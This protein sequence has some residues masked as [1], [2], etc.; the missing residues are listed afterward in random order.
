MLVCQQLKADRPIWIIEIGTGSGN[1]AVS[2]AKF[3]KNANICTIDVSEE[4]LELARA[5]ATRHAVE[6][7]ISFERM[8][9]FEP[10]DQLLLKRF[11]VL[12]SNPPYVSMKDWETLQLE[13]RKYEP[14]GAVC[15]GRDGFT[16][17]RRIIE[18]APYLLRD[19]GGL[20]LELGDHQ[21]ESV[22]GMMREAG[23]ASLSVVPDLQGLPRV[24]SSSCRS[25]TRNQRF[26]N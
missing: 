6:S 17:Y 11:D 3:I 15:D 25:K 12:V 9:V 2:L 8:D 1:I 21:S 5:N 24:V 26:A 7:L 16:Y 23:F 22:V 18:L 14:R 4:A 20:V 19:E 10:V 13:V